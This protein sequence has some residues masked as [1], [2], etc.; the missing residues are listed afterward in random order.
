MGIFF[1]F[2]CKFVPFYQPYVPTSQPCQ[3]LFYSATRRVTLVFQSPQLSEIR[4]YLSFSVTYFISITPARPIHGVAY[5]G[6]PSPLGLTNLPSCM[7]TF[8]LSSVKEHLGCY[9]ALAAV[10]DAAGKRGAD[11]SSGVSCGHRPVVGLLG[12]MVAPVWASWGNLHTGLHG[13]CTIYT[14]TLHTAPFPPRPRQHLLSLLDDSRPGGEV[15]D[16]SFSPVPWAA[17]HA[18]GFLRCEG[19]L[20]LMEPHSFTVALVACALVSH[21]PKLP[22]PTSTCVSF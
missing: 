13:G 21:P 19:A 3:P 9:Q 16:S 1:L 10:H 2:S 20:S 15:G 14:P 12:R 5:E 22:R 4:W 11:I 17:F 8:P 6:F 18:V 7:H